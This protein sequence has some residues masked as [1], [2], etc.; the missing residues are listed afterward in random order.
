MTNQLTNKESEEIQSMATAADLKA[1]EKQ[2]SF[3]QK[4]A[5]AEVICGEESAKLFLEEGIK[6]KF[7]EFDA[8][9]KLVIVQQIMPFD[10]RL[11]HTVLTP[12]KAR[13]AAE[14]Q[15]RWSVTIKVRNSIWEGKKAR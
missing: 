4:V 2:K 15:K 8:E 5:L 11:T 14:V 13:I 9:V 12:L 1:I 10:T 6:F 7:L 3:I